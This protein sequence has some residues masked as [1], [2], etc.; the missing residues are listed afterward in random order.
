MRVMLVQET[1][2]RY[3]KLYTDKR[4]E[5]NDGFFDDDGNEKKL[6]RVSG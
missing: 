3:N 4:T 6:P 5:I 2:F 1:I